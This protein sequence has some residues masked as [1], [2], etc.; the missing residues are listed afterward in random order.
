MTVHWWI[1]NIYNEHHKTFYKITQTG[2]VTKGNKNKPGSNVGDAVS[3][4]K[5]SAE[6]PTAHCVIALGNPPTRKTCLCDQPHKLTRVKTTCYWWL[7]ICSNRSM[8]YKYDHAICL[9]LAGY[10]IWQLFL[11]WWTTPLT[12]YILIDKYVHI[13]YA[14]TGDSNM[15][16]SM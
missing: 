15:Y 7:T 10:I 12:V 1:F 16:V 5:W 3:I 4:D 9:W 14:I 11:Y 13:I 2:M 6:S 8:T